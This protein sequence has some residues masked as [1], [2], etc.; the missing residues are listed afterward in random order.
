MSL[1][2]HGQEQGLHSRLIERILFYVIFFLK[3]GQ[4]EWLGWPVARV[5]QQ[6]GGAWDAERGGPL[7]LKMIRAFLLKTTM[8]S[9]RSNN[10]ATRKPLNCH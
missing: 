7:V 3:K 5:Y 9:P 2:R 6:G 8:A 4:V 10:N 1:F